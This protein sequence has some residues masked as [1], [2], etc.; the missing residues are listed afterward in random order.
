MIF[1]GWG[2]VKNLRSKRFLSLKRLG[3]N[4]YAVLSHKKISCGLKSL[5]IPKFANSRS[6]S[7]VDNMLHM[8]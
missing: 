3:N 7:K 1:L 5:Q 2:F 6:E 4:I 8:K